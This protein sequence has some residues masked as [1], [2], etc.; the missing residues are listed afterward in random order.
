MLNQ[1]DLH[2]YFRDVKTALKLV[3]AFIEDL[4][5]RGVSSGRIVHGK[6]T[7]NLRRTV[8]SHLEKH[9]LVAGC[10]TGYRGTGDHGA[11]IVHLVTDQTEDHELDAHL[12][13]AAEFMAEYEE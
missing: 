7:G 1:L 3:D 5:A 2:K 8:Q 9:P 11:T 12:K 6:G 13:E 4:K 10:V